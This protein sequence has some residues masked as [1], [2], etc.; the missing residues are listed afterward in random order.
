MVDASPE[1]RRLRR[2][3]NVGEIEKLARA[4]AI[5]DAVGEQV[6]G[7]LRAGMTELQGSVMIGTAIGEHGGTPPLRSPVPAGPQSR[8]PPPRAPHRHP[9][10]GGFRPPPLCAPHAP[11]PTPSAP[12][13][14]V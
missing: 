13:P 4:A 11:E 2:I 14:G 1:V 6:I 9:P 3:K 10:R 8:P 12:H 7:G 5:T